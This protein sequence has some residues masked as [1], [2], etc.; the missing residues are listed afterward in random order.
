VAQ[1]QRTLDE[2]LAE[3]RAKIVRL[4]PEEAMASLTRGALL[5]DIRSNHARGRD[6]VVPGAIHVPRTVLEWRFEPGGRWRSPWAGSLDQQLV[7]MCQDGYSSILAA[8]S[9]ADLGYASV[10]DVEGGFAR[11]RAA[12]L[13]VTSPRSVDPEE[14][15]GMGGPD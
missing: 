5:V 3:A 14:L 6:G 4:S 7:V 12:G 13:P 11:W 8:A 10:A 2:L 9:L 15:P 1:A